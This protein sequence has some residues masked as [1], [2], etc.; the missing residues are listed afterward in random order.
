MSQAILETVRRWTVKPLA[1]RAQI[2]GVNLGIRLEDVQPR[3]EP[4]VPV[5]LYP[6]MYTRARKRP[7]MFFDI[8]SAVAKR[9]PIVVEAR[10]AEADMITE[11]AMK[12]GRQRW[13]KVR[14][15]VP[16]RVEYWEALSHTT[17]FVAT[18]EDESY[19]LE[20]VEA[21]VAGAIGILPDLP[22]SRAIVPSDYPFFF[23]TPAEA[24]EMLYR[25]VTDT[26]GCRR[27]LDSCANGSFITWLRDHHDD[28]HFEAAIADH[29]SRWFGPVEVNLNRVQRS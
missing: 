18:S 10:L 29:V 28:S 12:L 26:E 24:E 27:Q 17:A 15:L 22:W 4:E 8:V 6:A 23:K 25:A 3:H 11:P 19:G 14:P 5:V 21:L 2:S 7:E 13:A 20:Y 16:R 1:E 9:T